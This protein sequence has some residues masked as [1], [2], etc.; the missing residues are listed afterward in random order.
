M[1]TPVRA[2]FIAASALIVISLWAYV[3]NGFSSEST[4]IPVGFGVLLLGL[5]FSLQARRLW[6]AIIAVLLTAIVVVALFTPLTSSIDKGAVWAVVRVAAM[7][8]AC[9]ASLIA[10]ALAAVKRAA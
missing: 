9:L 1:M 7:Q 6:A 10:F 5:H 4:L 3:L 8:I 2:N